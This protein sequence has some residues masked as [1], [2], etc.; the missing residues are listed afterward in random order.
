MAWLMAWLMARLMTKLMAWL[1]ARLLTKLMAWRRLRRRYP[2]RRREHGS[3]QRV[4]V[5]QII[6]FPTSSEVSE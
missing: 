5:Q 1:K 4:M 6:H 2:E 3:E